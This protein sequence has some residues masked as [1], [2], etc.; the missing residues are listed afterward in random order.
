MITIIVVLILIL[1]VQDTSCAERRRSYEVTRERTPCP[2]PFG[3]WESQSGPMLPPPPMTL[4]PPPPPIENTFDF[5]NHWQRIHTRHVSMDTYTLETE[6]P[7][8]VD[9][10]YETLHE[11]ARANDLVALQRMFKHE[12]HRDRLNCYNL[13]GQTP[14]QAAVEFSADKAI[15]FLVKMGA[16]VYIKNRDNEYTAVTLAQAYSELPGNVNIIPLMALQQA[17]FEKMGHPLPIERHKK[18]KRPIKEIK[19]PYYQKPSRIVKLSRRHKSADI[20]SQSEEAEY[21]PYL[22]NV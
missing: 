15:S 9:H 4:P 18:K 8:R 21:D 19:I 22:L 11:A 2:Q 13:E 20:S 1:S 7:F 14:L 3:P 10:Y 16:E 17:Y 5:Y 6:R 12:Y